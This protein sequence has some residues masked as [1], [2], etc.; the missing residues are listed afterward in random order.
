MKKGNLLCAA[1]AMTASGMLASSASAETVLRLGHVWPP[2]ELHAQAAEQFAE[3]VAKATDGEVKIEI[4]GG[5]TLGSDRE[6]IEG[7]RLGTADIWLGGAGNLSAASDTAKIFTVPFMFDDLEHF[8]TVYNGPVGEEITD[9]IDSESG[10]RVVA[11]WMRGPRWLTTKQR[12]ETPE[13]LKG[14]KIRVPDSPVFVRS[15]EMLGA[16]PTPMNFGEVFTA[17]QQGVIDGQE[18]PLSL[19]YTS[20]FAEVV[21]YLG[22]TEHVMEPITMVVG[23][24]RFGQL[25]E[26]HQQA[27]L[28][29]ANGRASEFV[30]EE[31]LSGE[32]E[33]LQKLQEEGMT[34]VE[35]DKEAFRAK[36]D[37]FVESAFP[38][39]QPIHE[40]IRAAAE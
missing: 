27:I 7:L 19:I 14:L 21:S 25:P 13:D 9:A 2:T 1:L 35:V 24:A 16:A 30:T 32:E 4:F 40:K 17:L 20:K 6:V 33:L 23:S 29:A 12:V 36:L 3:D 5:S 37:G 18:N 28:E 11:Y 10:Y 26:E 15:W 34:V 39:L 31:V 38:S 8:Q 22:S